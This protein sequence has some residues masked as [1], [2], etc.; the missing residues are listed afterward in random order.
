MESFTIRIE[1]RNPT[2]KSQIELLYT[3]LENGFSRTAVC[4]KGLTYALPANEYLYV[5]AENIRSLT[6]RVATLIDKFSHD[7]LVLVTQS[8][9]RCWSGLRGID[10]T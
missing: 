6:S 1:L 4:E 9:E 5:G 7:P 8:A 3:M 10:L 2:A